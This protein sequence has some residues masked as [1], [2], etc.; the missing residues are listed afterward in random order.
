ME[1][2]INLVSGPAQRSDS[3]ESASYTART[4]K[5]KRKQGKMTLFRDISRNRAVYVMLVPVLLYYIVFHYIPMLGVVIA[6]EDYMPALGIFKA[7]G[8]G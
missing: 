8:S 7:S 3:M 4:Q 2:L 6:F 5:L 1:A